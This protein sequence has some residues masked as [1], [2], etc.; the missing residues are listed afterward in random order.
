MPDI[1]KIASWA[2]LGFLTALCVIVMLRILTGELRTRGLIEGTTA[3]G[4]RFV[5]AGRVQ[6]LIATL[7]VAV[8]YASQAWQSPQRLPDVPQTWLLLL[9]GSHV[10][11]LGSKFHGKRNRRF[12]V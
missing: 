7:A 12:H 1:V 9:G 3:A 10:L 6:L 4:S 11:Y 8:R 5:S 2:A